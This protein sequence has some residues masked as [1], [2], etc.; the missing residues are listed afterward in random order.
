[1]E[2]IVNDLLDMAELDLAQEAFWEPVR[3]DLLAGEAF[4]HAR[5]VAAGLDF[6]MP[7]AEP[8]TV[9]GNPDWL[10]EL[11]LN[12]LDNAVKYTPAGGKV[13][14]SVLNRSPWAELVVADTGI[15]IPQDAQEK[16]FDRFY[17]VDKA[18]SRAKGGTGL[19]LAIAKAIVEAH[20]GHF[21]VASELGRGSTFVVRLPLAAGRAGED[22]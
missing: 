16:I 22:L 5:P 4:A 9:K 15:G 1:M 6:T 18:R 19:G 2:R 12:L 17:R 13:A 7:K 8:A 3:L 20:G 10:R 11:V 21:S 14:L